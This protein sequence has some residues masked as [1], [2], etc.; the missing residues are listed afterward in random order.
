MPVNGKFTSKEIDQM[1]YDPQKPTQRGADG[2]LVNVPGSAA[3]PAASPTTPGTQTVNTAQNQPDANW[4][5]QQLK[6]RAGGDMGAGRAIDLSGQKIR[7]AALG[8]ERSLEA[9][10][11]R[12]LG[13]SGGGVGEAARSGYEAQTQ[14]NIAGSAADIAAGREDKRDSVL[15][16][17]VS[18]GIQQ[19]QLN[20][21]DRRLALE[22]QQAADQNRRA[23][24]SAADARLKAILDEL[25]ATQSIASTPIPTQGPI[26]SS[27]PVSNGRG[28]VVNGG[29]MPWRG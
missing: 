9:G 25:A 17:I 15:G 3:A 8:G 10:L 18:G 5:V 1:G 23:E 13:G 21:G 22:Q 2:H 12:R 7:E 29:F 27:A 11:S 20:Q 4:A 19:G 24:E 16:S 6:Q 28:G 26:Q 14:R